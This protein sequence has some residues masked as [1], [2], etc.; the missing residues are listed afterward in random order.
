M[1]QFT[2]LIL[3]SMPRSAVETLVFTSMYRLYADDKKKSHMDVLMT[4][5][6]K[7]SLFGAEKKL[8]I[9]PQRRVRWR[10]PTQNLITTQ[11]GRGCWWQALNAH[12]SCFWWHWMFTFAKSPV[13]TWTYAAAMYACWPSLIS[14]W[15]SKLVPAA[16]L[17]TEYCIFERMTYRWKIQA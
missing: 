8:L 16:S 1:V 11:P 5:L 10:S 2:P 15:E 7:W 17:S 13:Q 3:K 6:R 9:P 12:H 14:F 4:Q